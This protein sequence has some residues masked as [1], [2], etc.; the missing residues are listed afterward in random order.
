MVAKLAVGKTYDQSFLRSH[1]IS[2]DQLMECILYKH[3]KDKGISVGGAAA[4][5]TS[6]EEDI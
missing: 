3:L 4:L 5:A 2:V 6:H 1:V